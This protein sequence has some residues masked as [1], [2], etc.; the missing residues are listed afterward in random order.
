MDVKLVSRLCLGDREAMDFL[1]HWTD[2]CHAIDDIVD[3]DKTDPEHVIATFARAATLYTH[4]FFLKHGA[5]LRE[6]ALN[7]T[8]TYAQTVEWERSNVEWMKAWADMHRH[9]SIEMV[10]AVARICGGYEHARTVIPE[11]RVVAFAEHHDQDGN[12]K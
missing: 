3:A 5:G 12:P 8:A 4:P 7:V 10:T 1:A 2:Y 9:C 11:V 6:V